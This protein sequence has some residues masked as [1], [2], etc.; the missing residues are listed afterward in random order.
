MQKPFKPCAKRLRIATRA[1]CLAALTACAPNTVYV[2]GDS[3]TVRITAGQPAPR[4][5]WL[6]SD[7]ALEDLLQCCE[8]KG[9]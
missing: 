5:G 1:L 8:G 3:Q 7:S 6:L 4:D 2:A 9:E